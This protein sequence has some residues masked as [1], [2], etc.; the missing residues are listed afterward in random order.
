VKLKY[1]I[2]TLDQCNNYRKWPQLWPTD[3]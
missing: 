3:E 2:Q 1:I